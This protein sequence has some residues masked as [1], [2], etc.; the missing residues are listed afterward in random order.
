MGHV[1][2]HRN[3]VTIM[4]INP[5]WL[6]EIFANAAELKTAHRQGTTSDAW[7][8][9][10]A[11]LAGRTAVIAFYEPSSRTYVSFDQALKQLGADVTPVMDAGQFSSA[12]KGETLR[13][14]TLTFGRYVDLM[15][16]RHP[17]KGS[18]REA[19]DLNVCSIINAGDGAGEHPTQALL[20][21]FTF[22]EK[23]EGESDKTLML[24]GDLKNG[25]T[26]HS[27]CDLIALLRNTPLGVIKAVHLVGPERL[28]LPDSYKSKLFGAGITVT[29]QKRL[30][31]A[32]IA[33]CDVI[34]T[35]RTQIER[36]FNNRILRYLVKQVAKFVSLGSGYAFTVQLAHHLKETAIV[37]HPLPRNAELPVAHDQLPQ[38]HYFEQVENGLYIRMALLLWIFRI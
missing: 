8:K 2:Q 35:T 3:F 23:F 34:Y 22:Y 20:D 27:L 5:E 10:S 29:E 33:Q 38:A 30:D 16:L 15:I 1:P 31:T 25:R 18:A 21:F 9:Y 4:G 26:V 32:S 28:A 24:V 13:D 17:Q 6:L 19:A 7:K 12:A 36:M 14:T 37:M 11:L